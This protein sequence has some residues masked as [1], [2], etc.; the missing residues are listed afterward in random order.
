L[1]DIGPAAFPAVGPLVNILL[2]RILLN[3]PSDLT[4]LMSVVS[5]LGAIGPAAEDAVE[6]LENAIKST[7]EV[8]LRDSIMEALRQ[9]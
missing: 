8:R 7:S 2:N 5:A 9:I 4:L 3:G 6:P 1:R